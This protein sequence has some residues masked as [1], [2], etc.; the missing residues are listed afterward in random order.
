MASSGVSCSRSRRSRTAA[1][2]ISRS[3]VL[4]R[5]TSVGCA[6]ST[7]L[8]SAEA[9]NLRRCAAPLPRRL[10]DATVKPDRGLPDSFDKIEHVGTLLV[11]HRVA[12]DPPE[13]TDVIPQ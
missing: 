2:S 3:M 6:V 5:R 7:G 9:R 4:L 8:T 1:I 10:V 12:Q 13:Q 11:T